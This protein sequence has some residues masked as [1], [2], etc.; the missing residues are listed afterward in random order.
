MT[1]R[2]QGC[3]GRCPQYLVTVSG[4]GDVTYYGGR[5]AAQTG[6]RHRKIPHEDVQRL[7]FKFR[8]LNYFSLKDNYLADKTE[9]AE[10]RATSIAYDGKRKEISEDGIDDSEMP[11]RLRELEA[12]ID[13]LSGSLGW[14]GKE[15][16]DGC[17]T[18]K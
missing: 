6:E 17:P 12:L 3:F 11:G 13:E 14:A 4:D 7:F 5:F 18:K 16:P 9:D 1:L 10:T 2:K 15:P 8:Q